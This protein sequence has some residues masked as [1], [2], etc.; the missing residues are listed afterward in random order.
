MT[1]VCVCVCVCVLSQGHAE[2]IALQRLDETCAQLQK[3]VC[4]CESTCLFQP[5]FIVAYVY[6]MDCLR[7]AI[8]LK[9]LSVWSEDLFCDNISSALRVTKCGAHVRQWVKCAIYWP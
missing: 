5:E 8:T 3:Q 6:F 1:C 7:R 9:L 4:E 2:L